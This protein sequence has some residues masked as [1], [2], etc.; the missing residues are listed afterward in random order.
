MKVGSL[1][2][3]EAR[4]HTSH[5]GVITAIIHTKFPLPTGKHR[6]KVF[7]ANPPYASWNEGTWNKK[8]LEVINESR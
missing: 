3:A 2:K 6:Y 5:I 4:D 8:E 1:V 7:F